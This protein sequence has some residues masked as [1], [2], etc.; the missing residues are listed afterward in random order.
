MT[1]VHLRKSKLYHHDSTRNRIEDSFFLVLK[2]AQFCKAIKYFISLHLFSQLF[3]KVEN[4]ASVSAHFKYE[5]VEKEIT[6]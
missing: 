3:M 6:K 5:A 1:K 4:E 2:F